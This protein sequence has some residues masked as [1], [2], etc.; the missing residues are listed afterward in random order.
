[1]ENTISLL[2]GISE[3][4]GMVEQQTMQF[5]FHFHF[6]F[7]VQKLGIPNLSD[8]VSLYQLLE[9]GKAAKTLAMTSTS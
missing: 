8:L 4:D 9:T 5:H 1:M 6:H 2:W 7:Q 3:Y